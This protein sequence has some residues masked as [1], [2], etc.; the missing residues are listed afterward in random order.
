MS[1][2]KN[3]N[4]WFDKFAN[5]WEGGIA[6]RPKNEDPAGYTN[7]GVTLKYFMKGNWGKYINKPSNKITLDALTPAE[8]KEIAFRAFWLP[9]RIGTIKD[10]R[11]QI[12]SMETVWGSGGFRGLLG[13]KNAMQVNE[14]LKKGVTF[15][16][17]YDSREAWLKKQPNA[18]YNAGW[19]DRL[20]DLLD[21]KANDL[22]TNLTVLLVFLFLGFSLLF[23][24]KFA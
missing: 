3:F 14:M 8:V 1:Y 23:V 2:P 15:K 21:L 12:L 11:T 17:F 20:D 6:N 9:F 7:R 24:N 18:K 10:N 4:T 13:A 19:F 16:Q 22:G 5:R